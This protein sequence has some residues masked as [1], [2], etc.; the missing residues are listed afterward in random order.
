MS[1]DRYNSQSTQWITPKEYEIQELER[2]LG[3]IS[4][5]LFI[6]LK[7]LSILEIKL[8]TRAVISQNDYIKNAVRHAMQQTD[9]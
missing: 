4:D 1:T 9:N 3:E 8:L 7:K 6:A 5:E 2:E